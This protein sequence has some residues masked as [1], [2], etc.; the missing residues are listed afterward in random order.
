MTKGTGPGTSV[1]TIEVSS[2]SFV[3]PLLDESTRPGL[4]LDLGS[5]AH[6]TKA[7]S[8]GQLKEAIAGIGDSRQKIVLLER[9]VTADLQ[10]LRRGV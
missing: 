5:L 3:V 8:S 1:A 2:I 7:M 10:V 6:Y 4:C 9:D